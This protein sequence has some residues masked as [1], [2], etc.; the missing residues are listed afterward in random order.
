MHQHKTM[1]VVLRH[2]IKSTQILCLKAGKQLY[3]W[4]KLQFS[5]NYQKSLKFNEFFSFSKFY[6]MHD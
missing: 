4:D 6:L 2:Q 3:I 5:E 1:S